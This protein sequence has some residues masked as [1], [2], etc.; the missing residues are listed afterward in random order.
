MMTPMINAV[1]RSGV[2][3]GS[4]QT[5]P[6]PPHP[7]PGRA[8]LRLANPPQPSPPRGG[9]RVRGKGEGERLGSAADRRPRRLQR[10]HRVGAEDTAQGEAGRGDLA[11]GTDSEGAG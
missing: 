3:P 4:A 10:E 6:S 7:A 1:A 5:E 2:K 11:Q 8:R 9:G